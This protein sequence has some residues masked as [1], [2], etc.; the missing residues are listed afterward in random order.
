MK[1]FAKARRKPGTMNQTE[2]RY[3]EL[4]AYKQK[5]GEIQEFHFEA[6]TLKLATD[7]RYTPDFMVITN[8]MELEFH[9]VKGYWMDDAKVKIKVASAKF[10]FRF[11]A[12]QYKGGN[13]VME[14]F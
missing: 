3:S 1:R 8:E 5:N 7:T 14:E 4:L 2:R 10:P 12:I 6:I 11:V 13:W 9:E